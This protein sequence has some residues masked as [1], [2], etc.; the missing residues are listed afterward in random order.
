MRCYPRLGGTCVLLALTGMAG[1]ARAAA[2]PPPAPADRDTVTLSDSQLHSVA[3]V[4]V[5]V[6]PFAAE[7]PAVGSVG[8][9][10]NQ[11]VQVFSPYPGR[12]LEA[13]PDLGDEVRKGQVLFTI[14]SP[15]FIAA[16]AN[17]IAAA[18]TRDQTASALARAKRLYADKAID[19]N[20]YETALANAESAEG[21]LKAAR[22][23]VGVFGRTPA[24]IDAIIARREVERELIVKSPLSGRITARNA[25]PGLFVQP[26]SVPA[27]YAVADESTMWMLASVA[28]A[29]SALVHIG[30][31]VKASLLAWPGRIFSGEVTAL[32][33]SIDPNTRRLT[34]RMEIKDPA[35][36]LKSGMFATFLIRT[37]QPAQALAVPLDS[38]V[39]EGDGTLSV[40]VVQKD[41]HV[42][43]RRI[44]EVG[45]VQDGYDQIL[46]GIEPGAHVASSGAIFLSNILFGGAT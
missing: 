3:V 7:T 32:G 20:D 17:L 14:E 43:K 38:V 30:Q 19:Q 9:N 39:R 1:V 34:V 12:I 26:G 40:W 18:A 25:A 5:T 10:E 44:V 46:S 31:P 42:F 24:E 23:A 16:E 33:A 36:E 22:G 15:D 41:P 28:E 8:F 2:A 6:R 37:G 35:H 13:T 21:A 27:P 11:S 29:D 4:P 45:L